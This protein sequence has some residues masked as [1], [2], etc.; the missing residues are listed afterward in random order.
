MNIQ[1]FLIVATGRTV[2]SLRRYA[3]VTPGQPCG[4]RF[5]Y[6]NAMTQV[7][8]VEGER[9]GGATDWPRD[10]PRWPVE[11]EHCAYRFTLADTW[12]LFN[13][14]EYRR[15]DNGKLTTLRLA[16]IGAMWWADWMT[17]HNS[18]T[19]HRT[20]RGDGPHLMVK[21]P[22]G[23]WDIDSR[24]SNANGDGWRRRGDPPAIVANPSIMIGGYHGYLG[25]SAG[26]KP[27]VLVEC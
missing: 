15:T 18:G 14:H 4:G 22:G 8:V 27:G 25:G 1:C 11:C 17:G 13:E 6:H 21:T 2:L 19:F 16:D 5:G 23:D 24:S 12:N 9:A 3:D 26:D 20:E 7:D 10:D